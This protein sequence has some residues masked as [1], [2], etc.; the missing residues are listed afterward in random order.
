LA[1]AKDQVALLGPAPAAGQPPEPEQAALNRAELNYLFGLLSAGQTAVPS[2]QLR[3]DHLI[4]TIHD[5]RPKKF[6]TRLFHPGPGIYSFR[7]WAELP[8]YVPLGASH[9]RGILPDWWD[10]I[11]DQNGVLL[12]AFEAVLLW[13]VLTFVAWHGV[14]RLRRW[15]HEGEPPFWRRAS[16]AAGVILLRILPVV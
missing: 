1:A 6:S 7:A 14:P 9:R 2:P 16:S 8:D 4:N 11:R 3:I 15:R 5:V 12:I 10:S 13:V